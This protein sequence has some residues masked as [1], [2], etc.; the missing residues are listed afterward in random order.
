MIVAEVCKLYKKGNL[1]NCSK[2]QN[3]RLFEFKSS[4]TTTF[5]ILK[6]KHCYFCRIIYTFLSSHN[7]STYLLRHHALNHFYTRTLSP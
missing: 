2:F 7:S 3:I 4:F 5:G 1:E 6:R